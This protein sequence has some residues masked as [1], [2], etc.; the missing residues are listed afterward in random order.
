MNLAVLEINAG[1]GAR[2][3]TEDARSEHE[4]NEQL[5]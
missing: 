3:E 1:E 2:T 4:A 5:T